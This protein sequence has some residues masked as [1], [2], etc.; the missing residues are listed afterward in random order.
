VTRR[1]LILGEGA[2]ELRASGERWAGCARVE[3]NAAW[4]CGPTPT[5][6]H[7]NGFD[8]RIEHWSRFAR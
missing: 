7:D 2:T 4:T 1:I 8:Y 3:T 5:Q 6:H